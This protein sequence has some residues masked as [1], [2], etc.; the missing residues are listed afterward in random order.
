MPNQMKFQKTSLAIAILLAE[1][2]TSQSIAQRVE[3]Q[4]SNPQWVSM[5]EKHKELA[6]IHKAMASCLESDKTADL[7][8]QEMIE[9]CSSR[10]SGHCPMMNMDR[11]GHPEEG[12]MHKRYTDG[13]MIPDSETNTAPSRSP[14]N[15][16]P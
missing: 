12:M 15:S 2:T 14:T 16:R 10:F 4:P 1:I 8:S 5:S 7:C 11:T 13:M 9:A 3:S 6:E